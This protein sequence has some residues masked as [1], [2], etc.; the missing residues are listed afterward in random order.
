MRIESGRAEGL[1]AGSNGPRPAPVAGRGRAEQGVAAG[2]VPGDQRRPVIDR[3]RLGG[4]HDVARPGVALPSRGFGGVVE[5][6][7]GDHELVDR[8][9]RPAFVQHSSRRGGGERGEGSGGHDPRRDR[10]RR[11]SGRR[12]FPGPPVLDRERGDRIGPDRGGIQRQRRG[13][14]RC[15]EGTRGGRGRDLG[16]RVAEDPNLVAHRR[17]RAGVERPR[18]DDL[19]VEYR[20][21]Q[22]VDPAE[23]QGRA[24]RAGPQ[25][26][27]DQR[28]A[29]RIEEPEL[30]S[31]RRIRR[32]RLQGELERQRP[33]VDRDRKHVRRLVR[34]EGADDPKKRDVRQALRCGGSRV[35]GR[36]IDHDLVWKEWIVRRCR[37]PRALE[38]FPVANRRV[39]RELGDVDRDQLRGIRQ[40]LEHSPG[41]FEGI[42]QIGRR[43]QEPSGF[44]QLQREVCPMHPAPVLGRGPLPP[45]DECSV[46]FAGHSRPHVIGANHPSARHRG[47][48]PVGQPTLS[49]PSLRNR[50]QFRSN[51][52]EKSFVPRLL[53]PIMIASA[54]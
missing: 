19:Q 27:V 40:V 35:G 45:G 30:R 21:R 42:L 20:A 44:E 29:Q 16:R 28:S 23:A 14:R 53:G 31:V 1:P 26:P 6:G 52:D 3:P 37:R 11:R 33:R 46:G 47:R 8:L 2:T 51:C 25:R 49:H 13:G 48:Q 39:G 43:G 9:V 41:G 50:G 17:G 18:L 54:P 34:P 32:I 5:A 7:L 4:F 22:P 36:I 12:G 24:E 38:A 10:D 15:L